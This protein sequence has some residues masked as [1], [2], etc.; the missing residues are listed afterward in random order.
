MAK[1]R[2]TYPKD[3]MVFHVDWVNCLLG[4]YDSMY[5]LLHKYWLITKTFLDRT[6]K[7]IDTELGKVRIKSTIFEGKEIHAKVEFDDIKRLSLLH[8]LSMSEVERI[9][10]KKR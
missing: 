9:V 3:N 6:E 8:G 7:E 4:R 2:Q 1:L 5:S 10:N